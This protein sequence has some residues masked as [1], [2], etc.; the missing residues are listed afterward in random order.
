MNK[1]TTFYWS[2]TP[3]H[4]VSKLTGASIAKLSHST[5]RPINTPQLEEKEILLTWLYTFLPFIK[6]TIEEKFP[7]ILKT[8]ISFYNHDSKLNTDIVYHRKLNLNCGSYAFELLMLKENETE[9]N[10]FFNIKLDESIDEK[11]VF[12]SEKD[13]ILE[14]KI[15]S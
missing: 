7:N 6:E 14:F 5:F 9:I 12:F 13:E 2:D 3:G 8:S 11:T 4:L 15:I 1:K 10:S